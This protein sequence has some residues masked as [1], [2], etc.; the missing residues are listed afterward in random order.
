[1]NVDE[2]GK[3]G[4]KKEREE[5]WEGR[6]G[7]DS[8]KLQNTIIEF[9]HQGRRVF[10][11]L[12]SYCSIISKPWTELGNVNEAFWCQPRYPQSKIFISTSNP[13]FITYTWRQLDSVNLVNT[14]S[15]IEAPI[16]PKFRTEVLNSPGVFVTLLLVF[17]TD[18]K[19][20]IQFYPVLVYQSCF[21]GWTFRSWQ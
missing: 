20:S 14:L 7:T 2:C 1:M 6:Q 15:C 8:L 18:S 9:E 10:L 17:E 5:F 11:Q 4:K 13:V 19:V 12:V 16:S 21:W 3:E